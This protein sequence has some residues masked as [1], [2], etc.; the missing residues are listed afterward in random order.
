MH[1]NEFL[2]GYAAKLV[3]YGLAVTYLVLFVGFWRYVQGGQRAE[4]SLPEALPLP[5]AA[6]A[7]GWFTVPDGVSLHP[8]HAWA[9]VE[10]DGCVAVGL[11]DLGHRLVGDLDAVVVPEPGTRVEQGAASVTLRAGGKDVRLLSPVDGEVVEANR[12]ADGSADPYGAGWLFRVRPSHWRRN[13]A[14]LLSGTAA[15]SWLEE[16]GRRLATRLSPEPVPVLQDGGAPVHGIA[17]EIDP[18]HWDDVAR[19][20]FRTQD[21]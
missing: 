6:A 19:E 8:G 16:Q 21:A 13:R 9:R 12:S 15:R 7:T 18:D 4:E 11:D 5:R 17:R 20:F 3:E 10:D 2:S 1:G 14:Q